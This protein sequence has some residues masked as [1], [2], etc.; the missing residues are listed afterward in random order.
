MTDNAYIFFGIVSLL[1]MLAV[2]GL[3]LIAATRDE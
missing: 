2:I 1:A 3:E